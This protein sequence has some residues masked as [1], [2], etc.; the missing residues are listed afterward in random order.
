MRF[1]HIVHPR[2]L[3]MVLGSLAIGAAYFAVAA[4]ATRPGV[5]VFTPEK[6][7]Y[8][9]PVQSAVA[10][11]ASPLDPLLR[12]NL[13]EQRPE[14]FYLFDPQRYDPPLDPASARLWLVALPVEESSEGAALDP[15]L[16]PASITAVNPTLYAIRSPQLDGAWLRLH[17]VE[18][19]ARSLSATRPVLALTVTSADGQRLV[20]FGLSVD[21]LW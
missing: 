13:P 2:A 9:L 21:R 18:L 15:V 5:Y 4:P 3:A 11:P 8:S 19:A 14:Y 17:Y 1:S 7:A 16:V 6:Q 20:V 12:G 10:T